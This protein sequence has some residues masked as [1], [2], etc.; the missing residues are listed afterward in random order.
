MSRTTEQRR[1]TAFGFDDIQRFA[2]VARAGAEK[3]ESR[4][5]EVPPMELRVTSEFR[6]TDEQWTV[7]EM[8]VAECTTGKVVVD[9]T[10]AYCSRREIDMQVS[11]GSGSIVVIVPRGWRIDL[12]AV[13]F[14]TGHVV[15][16]VNLPRFPGAP[17][18]RIQGH[19]ESGVL[20]A[21]YAHRSPAEW[22]R[23]SR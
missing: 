6:R 3:R 1:V 15:N 12:E 2:E 11:A 23:R 22:L 17:L 14:G 9:F 8:L 5:R 18:I 20:K 4:T 16:R 21:R 19:V 7:P 10:Q 13:E